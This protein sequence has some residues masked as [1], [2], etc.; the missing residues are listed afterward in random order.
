MQ[1]R[2]RPT[3]VGNEWMVMTGGAEAVNYDMGANIHTLLNR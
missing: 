1:K 2:Y 3:D